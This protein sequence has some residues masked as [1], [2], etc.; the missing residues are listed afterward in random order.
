[1]T[2][3]K[4]LK[5]LG[6]AKTEYQYDKP[7]PTL[8][9]TFESPAFKRLGNAGGGMQVSIQA[10]EFT[11]LCPITGQPDWATISITYVPNRLCLE[12]KSLK[13][14]LMG[15][16]NY[17][18]FHEAIVD[19]IFEDLIKLLDP[20]A[21]TIQGQFDPRGG[22]KFWPKIEYVKTPVIQKVQG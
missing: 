17:G 6:S 21:M 3:T 20:L 12:S 13:L 14:Y 16:R 18:S 7:D 10:P 19:E 4:D 11:S 9:E 5:A 15:Y 2:I 22:I 1:M 8:L